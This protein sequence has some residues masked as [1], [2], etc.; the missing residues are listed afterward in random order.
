MPKNITD[1]NPRPCYML[2]SCLAYSSTLKMEA[3]CSSEMSVHFERTKRRY[4]P[5]DITLYTPCIISG[6]SPNVKVK[7]K[8]LPV[9]GRE[10]PWGYETSK[11][12][13]FF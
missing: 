11:L 5:G 10:G 3:T 2:V 6:S 13:H 9:T 12:P 4:I 8:A 7:G 1:N